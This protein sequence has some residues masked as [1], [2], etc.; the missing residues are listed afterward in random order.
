MQATT[1]GMNRTGAVASPAGSQA[2]MQ[3]ADELTPPMPID[4]SSSRAQRARYINES[5]PVGSIPIPAS[6]KGMVKSGIAKLKGGNPSILLDKIGERVAFERGGTRL[7]DALLTKYEA[8]SEMD[9]GLLPTAEEAIAAAGGDVASHLQGESALETMTRIRAEELQHFGLL[10][11]AMTGL[12]GDPTA[13][14]PCADVTA[15]ASMGLIQVVT[16]PRTTL[17]QSLNVMLTAELTD[18]AGWELLIQLAD[19]AGEAELAGQF[20][21]AL[22]QEQEHLLVVKSWL[23]TLVSTRAGTPAV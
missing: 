1:P 3:A 18:N 4:T 14:T 19:E 16:D 17:A 8:V 12:G 11:D 23:A 7:Y 13:Q 21:A 20:L 2:M 15:T 22:S 10:C 6:M 5:E 9:G